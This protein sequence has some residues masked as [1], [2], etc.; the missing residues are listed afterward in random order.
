MFKDILMANAY[1]HIDITYVHQTVLVNKIKHSDL[2]SP[3]VK[4]LL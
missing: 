2:K 4:I 3:S 1:W